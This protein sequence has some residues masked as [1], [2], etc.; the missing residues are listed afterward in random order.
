MRFFWW[1]VLLV[2]FVVP[3]ILIVRIGW[4]ISQHS[5]ECESGPVLYAD[6]QGNLLL[7][8]ET[9]DAEALEILLGEVAEM[10]SSCVTLSLGDKS[11]F[12][13]ANRLM[14]AADP[15]GVRVAI[16]HLE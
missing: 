15:H 16:D 5:R 1:A 6:S 2:F 13:P 7:S 10:A 12:G 14:S 9:L 4:D 11:L 8:D 3:A